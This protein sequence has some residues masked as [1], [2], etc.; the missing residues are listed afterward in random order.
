[1]QDRAAPGLDI[2]S[3]GAIIIARGKRRCHDDGACF[4]FRVVI[5]LAGPIIPRSCPGY[6]LLDELRRCVFRFA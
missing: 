1:M 3:I 5:V 4:P 6:P 2:G